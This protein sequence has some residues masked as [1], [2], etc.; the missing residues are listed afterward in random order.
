M[1]CV[2]RGNMPLDALHPD[3][4]DAVQWQYVWLLR[5][6]PDR[7]QAAQ[8]DQAVDCNFHCVFVFLFRLNQQSVSRSLFHA[9]SFC[10]E[11]AA[12][13]CFCLNSLSVIIAFEHWMRG[14]VES[15]SK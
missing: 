15:D 4:L 9:V 13:R 11:D 2:S 10:C 12:E 5:E 1:A 8:P 3:S 6:L 7:N 14:R